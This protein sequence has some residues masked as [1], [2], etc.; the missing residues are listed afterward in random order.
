MKDFNILLIILDAVRADH[1]SCYG[2]H[3]ET[4]PVID[5]IA[6]EG[7]LYKNAISASCW[8]LES[9]ASIFTGLLP[10]RHGAHWA[11]QKIDNNVKLISEYFNSNDYRTFCLSNNDCFFNEDTGLAKG[12]KHFHNIKYIF[13]PTKDL[14]C[15]HKMANELYQKIF[16]TRYRFNL[17]TNETNF[18]KKIYKKYLLGK[19]HIGAAETNYRLKRLIKDCLKSD[20]PFFGTVLYI[21]AHLP[22]RPPVKFINKFTDDKTLESRLNNINFDAKKFMA[23]KISMDEKD[24]HVLNCLYD[25]EISYIDSKIGEIY[26][27]LENKGLLDSTMLIITSDHG[28]NIGEHSLMDHRYCLYDTVLRVPLIIRFP[29]AFKANSI[30]NNIVQTT[31]IFPTLLQLLKN[32]ETAHINAFDGVSLFDRPNLKENYAF[33]EYLYPQPVSKD[34]DDYNELRKFMHSIKA[35]RD[36]DFKYILYSDDTEFLFDIRKDPDELNNVIEANR[37][38]AMEMKQ[39]LLEK[40]G[41]FREI[42]VVAD[43]DSNYK[44]RLKSL[45]YL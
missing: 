36:S 33:S 20:S 14:N 44:E 28:E 15:F 11:S 24:F 45:G 43:L 32:D 40:T 41:E 38:T 34:D 10:N 17:N 3:R 1:L 42:H 7:T 27:F 12:F 22:Y 23:G 19:F 35:V 29:Q 39:R 31:D 13:Y 16:Y 25:A 4:S 8:T 5:K 21:D 30:V 37:K 9:I 26:K 6:S 2:Y 18:L